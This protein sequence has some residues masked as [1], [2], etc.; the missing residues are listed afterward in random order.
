MC[1]TFVVVSGPTQLGDEAIVQSLTEVHDVAGPDSRVGVAG[2][3][4]SVAVPGSLQ[5]PC[6]M[7]GSRST[8]MA[9]RGASAISWLRHSGAVAGVAAARMA[10][11]VAAASTGRSHRTRERE[12]EKDFFI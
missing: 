12:R 1:S 11:A 3:W 5:R 9:R 7:E 8:G 2:S 6:P 4:W 10:A